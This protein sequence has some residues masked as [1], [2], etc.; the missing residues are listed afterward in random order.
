MS[1]RVDDSREHGN[2]NP[3]FHEYI[4]N[5]ILYDKEH[6]Y[7]HEPKNKIEDKIERLANT[8]GRLTEVLLKEDVIS[9][10]AAL[11]IVHVD[12]DDVEI[13]YED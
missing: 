3:T 5:R 13:I 1:I 10:K 8:I 9:K 7:G 6:D 12:E 2:W 11:S 4:S